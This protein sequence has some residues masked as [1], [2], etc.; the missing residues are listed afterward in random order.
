M[1]TSPTDWSLWKRVISDSVCC[2]LHSFP[3]GG[4]WLRSVTIHTITL[5]S[6]RIEEP[7]FLRASPVHLPCWWLQPEGEASSFSVLLRHESVTLPD[8][9]HTN[10]TSAPRDVPDQSIAKGVRG[11]LYSCFLSCC[12][13]VY[14]VRHDM[15]FGHSKFHSIFSVFFLILDCSICNDV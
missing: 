13:D 10:W 6:V 7:S 12:T 9:R 5:H 3:Q 4:A 1:A 15:M 11:M 8:K 14:H 2:L